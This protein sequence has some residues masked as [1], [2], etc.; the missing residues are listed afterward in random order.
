MGTVPPDWK[1]AN[2]VPVHKK[3]DKYDVNN[4]R[5]ISL[6]SLVVKVME[7]CIRNELYDK[8]KNLICDKQHGFLPGKSRT[9]QMIP[10]IDNVTYSLTHEDPKCFAR[11]SKITARQTRNVYPWACVC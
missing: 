2:V 7:I 10:F 5:P 1:L 6:T 4:Y 9:T 3:G 8:C 11:I